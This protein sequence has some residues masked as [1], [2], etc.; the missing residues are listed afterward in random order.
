MN[1]SLTNHDHKC[2]YQIPPKNDKAK[3]IEN[4]ND[5]HKTTK[6]LEIFLISEENITII[7]HNGK[8]SFFFLIEF[9]L[10]SKI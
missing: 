7:I 4:I 6:I 10:I 2:I 3:Q 1:T 5:S 9:F 8:I